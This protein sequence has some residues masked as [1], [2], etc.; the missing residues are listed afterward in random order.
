MP[1]HIYRSICF[2]ILGILA[3][4]LI[5]ASQSGLI[6]INT[7]SSAELQT[8]VGIGAVKAQAIIDYRNGPNGPFET[9]EEIKDVSGIGE[10]T[11]NNIKD[12]ITVGDPVTSTSTAVSSGES[13]SGSQSSVHYSSNPLTNNRE[14]VSNI[15]INIGKDR[16]GSIGSP[17]EFKAETNLNYTRSSIFKWNFGD[18]SE[19]HGDLLTHTYEY[20][21]DYTVVLNLSLPS[22]GQTVSKVNVK[23]VDPALTVVSATPERIE[24]KNNSKFDTSLFGRA[25]VVGDKAFLFPQDT[26]IKASQGIFFSS[27]VTELKPSN[28][29]D[30]MLVTMGDKRMIRDIESEI[31][32]YKSEKVALI[33]S[34]ITDLQQRIFSMTQARE[35][36]IEDIQ[37]EVAQARVEMSS[38][39]NNQV[40]SVTKSGLWE[41]LK[42]FFLRTE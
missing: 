6:N 40:A 4:P 13:S 34:Q 42:R 25:L 23:I 24:I 36:V 33:R 18:G 10:A 26:I 12:F 32:R 3:I 7:A 15:S 8:L 31:S 38:P 27:K 22:G 41:T 30:V 28:I 9:I 5:V 29:Y 11:Y 16:T 37:P 19:G 2:V 17:M 14:Q 39:S 21:G 20:P 35:V 1:E